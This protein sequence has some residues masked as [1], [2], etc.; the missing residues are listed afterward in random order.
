MAAAGIDPTKPMEIW[1]APDS[2]FLAA[3]WV[4]IGTAPD[5]IATQIHEPVPGLG[6]WVTTD[7]SM[8]P[9][10]EFGEAPLLQVELEW[11]GQGLVAMERAIWPPAQAGVPSRIDAHG[12]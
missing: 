6:W 9:G 4:C 7:I 5:S 11:D 2:G 3:W 12:A 1:G 8:R 10:P